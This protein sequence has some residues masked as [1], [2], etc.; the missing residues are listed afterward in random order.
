MRLQPR[1]GVW[2]WDLRTNG[3]SWS[4]EWLQQ[5]GYCTPMESS[6]LKDWSG[7]VHPEDLLG[8]TQ[9]LLQNGHSEFRVRL[10]EGA[11]MPAQADV[12]GTQPDRQGRPIRLTGSISEVQTGLWL[13]REAFQS[14]DTSILLLN[15]AGVL[16]ANSAAELTLRLRGGDSITDTPVQDAVE[17]DI[18]RNFDC[19]WGG[20]PCHINLSRLPGHPAVFVAVVTDLRESQQLQRQQIMLAA[21]QRL[22]PLGLWQWDCVGGKIS[23]SARTFAIFNRRP[24]EGEPTY[25]ELLEMHTVESRERLDLLVNRAIQFGLE[26]HEDF[27]LCLGVEKQQRWIRAVGAARRDSSGRVIELMGSVV[28][29]TDLMSAQTELE[30]ARQRAEEAARAKGRFL[31]NL[32]HELRTPMNAIIGLS[33]LLTQDLPEGAQLQH[34]RLIQK[35]GENLLQ[36]I[37]EILDFSK[38]EAGKLELETHDFCLPECLAETVDLLRPE[39]EA[40]GLQVLLLCRTTAPQYLKGDSIRFRQILYNLMGNAIKFTLRGTVTLILESVECSDNKVNLRLSVHDTGIGIAP[41]RLEHLFEP[42]TQADPSTARRFGGTGL[43]LT[44][45]RALCQQM[46]GD[47]TAVSQPDQGS[48]FTFRISMQPGSPTA[49][50]QRGLT[51][52]L[53]RSLRLMLAEDNAVNQRV[54]QALL[55]R[56]GYTADLANNGLE[57]VEACKLKA[58]DV[59]LMDLQMPELDG[60]EATRRLRQSLP[61]SQQPYIIALTANVSNSDRIDC[62][63]AGMNDFLSKPIRL[64]D[65]SE[66][67]QRAICSKGPPLRTSFVTE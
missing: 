54:C 35:S 47:L 42:F 59:V 30:Q 17:A 11:W 39:A 57:A 50:A 12:E 58:Y 64:T 45:S 56:L 26:Y 21:S 48:C 43:G 2:E 60:L 53:E 16:F 8:M 20:I 10:P 31:A 14:S 44:I 34:L 4:R 52:T 13:F 62:A 1:L 9:Q 51:E 32:S 46:G 29:I 19:A 5:L 49:Q 61:Q 38:M 27:E 67:L 24:E 15:R 36:Q 3:V 55:E 66:A 37:N 33:S 41:D 63:Q 18:S 22:A 23:W 6:D 28:D 25:S 7:L 65:L 40:R